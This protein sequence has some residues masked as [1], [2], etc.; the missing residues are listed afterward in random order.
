MT[1]KIDFKKE[2]KDY[3]QPPHADFVEIELP[4][5]RYVM[6]DGA[7]NPNTTSVYARA[8]EWLYSTSYAL[9][10]HSKQTLGKDYVVPPLEG[11]WWADDPQD[12]V[13]RNK[14]AWHWTMMIMLPDF[15]PQ[16][17]FEEAS[18][19]T[20]KKL[21]DPPDTLRL[22]SLSEGHCLQIM[23]IGSYDD[24]GPTLEQLHDH[25]MPQRGLTFNGHHHE[26]YISD[27]R[28]T[29]K[30]RLKT[31][32]RQPVCPVSTQTHQA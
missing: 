13:R 23:H 16:E 27:P 17:A 1:T 10:F 21:G 26:I 4:P 18:L 7:G 29:A 5:L 2:M 8:L 24:E 9:K 20:S 12:F 25:I 30:E 6:V 11:L 3:F 28:R 22:R 14:D 19:K 31:V 32:L 15:V